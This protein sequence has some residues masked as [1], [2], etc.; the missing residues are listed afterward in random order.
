MIEI[1]T[2]DEIHELKQAKPL[3]LVSGG[4]D[5]TFLFHLFLELKKRHGV[6]FTVLHVNHGLR[7][8]ESDDD[9]NF[10]RAL[11]EKSK[12]PYVLK[13]LNFTGKTQIQNRARRTRLEICFELK[14]KLSI[15]HVVTAHH[16]DD[17]IETLVMKRS[18]GSGLKGLTGIRRRRV[19]SHPSRQRESLVFFR[20]LLALPKERLL[21]ILKD[22]NWSYRVDSSNLTAA[23]TRNRTRQMLA[24]LG[25][26]AILQ[27]LYDLSLVA[28][29]LDEHF[30]TLAG[31]LLKRVSH[32]IP[33]SVWEALPEEVQFRVFRR[34][35]R[36]KGY[37]KQIE[38]RHFAV[39]SE[40][41][42]KL[43]LD[44]ACALKDGAGL[45][46]YSLSDWQKTVIAE[47][48]PR[49]GCCHWGGLGLT[50]SLKVLKKFSLKAL[51]KT[52]DKG[53]LRTLFVNAEAC[54]L[55]LSL[56]RVPLATRM[57][58]FGKSQV[59]L[60]D[61]FQARGVPLYRR[62][63]IP[64]LK[65]AEGQIVAA[66]GVEISGNFKVTPKTKTVLQMAVAWT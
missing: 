29:N 40:S 49:S 18:R 64:V 62:K 30:E 25:D 54:A 24:K 44:E 7:G 17:I 59:S 48:L 37:R 51:P 35:M 39:F 61:L 14:K 16:F 60:K 4:P 46:F 9:E 38:R 31:K 52:Q 5:S 53:F 1:L 10:V 6:D 12:I 22:E 33:L 28:Q 42:A 36:D 57:P 26:K 32:F 65:D 55:P 21:K 56:E 66:V 41:E 20:P 8:N 11:C 34:K 58:G 13:H 50:L 63:L 2:T 23:Y 19:L 27:T 15:T 45:Y 3:V 43:F 47:K